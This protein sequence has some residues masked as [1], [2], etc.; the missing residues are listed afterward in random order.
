VKDNFGRLLF[1]APVNEFLP[2]LYFSIP[3]L[4]SMMPNPLPPAVSAFLEA[5]VDTLIMHHQCPI[6]AFVDA[7]INAF[8][9]IPVSA[10]FLNAPV[11]ASFDAFVGVCFNAM[12]LSIR[13]QV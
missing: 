5:P 13:R 3:M 7:P 12:L 4:L 6:N 2:R 11:N 8:V 1:Y 9:N 10:W